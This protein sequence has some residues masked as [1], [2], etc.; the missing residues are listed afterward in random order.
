MNNTNDVSNQDKAHSQ[1]Q[2]YSANPNA[3][4]NIVLLWCGKS[5]SKIGNTTFPLWI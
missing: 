3:I 5:K 2:N 4:E 1:I